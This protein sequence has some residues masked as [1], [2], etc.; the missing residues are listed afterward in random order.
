MNQPLTWTINE[1]AL[2]GITLGIFGFV[3]LRRGVSREL[4]A[5]IG[6]GLGV[7]IAGELASVAQ[8]QVNRLYKLV[9]LALSGG[10]TSDNPAAAW[11]QV[12]GLPPLVSTAEDLQSLELVV[13]MLVAL[14]FY[15][16]GQ[17]FVAGSTGLLP[18]LL[19]LL[20]GGINGFL[21]ALYLYPAIFSQPTAVLTVS[22]QEVRK[23]LVGGEN[24]AV[25]AVF[26]V[27]VLIAFGLYSAGPSRRGSR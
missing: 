23:T 4:L 27:I 6:I 19:G 11:Q 9:Q 25:V 21:V 15:L 13:F 12:S 5:M 17:R 8:P 7:L 3:G 20:A 1:V 22:G 24:L 10:L 2:V 26:F 18:R 14:A 16:L